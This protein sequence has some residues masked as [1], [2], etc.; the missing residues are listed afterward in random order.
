MGLIAYEGRL[1]PDTISTDQLHD[2]SINEARGIIYGSYLGLRLHIHWS[3]IVNEIESIGSVKTVIEE[4]SHYDTAYQL[5][6]CQDSISCPAHVYDPQ[7]KS[8]AK[9]EASPEMA[10]LDRIIRERLAD[11]ESRRR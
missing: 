9:K 1:I 2:V 6:W 3:G 11:L 10:R 4:M 7:R 5:S 8:K